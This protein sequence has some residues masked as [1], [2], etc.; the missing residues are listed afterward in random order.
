[1]RN[2]PVAHGT[3]WATSGSHAPGRYSRRRAAALTDAARDAV[4][5]EVVTVGNGCTDCWVE[6]SGRMSRGA[7]A[8]ASGCAA[9][10][11]TSAATAPGVKLRSLLAGATH[12]VSVRSA[13]TFTAGP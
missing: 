11:P 6:P 12:A 5:S 13:T 4:S 9:P 8:P 1:M 10:V 3:S 7:I 2:A